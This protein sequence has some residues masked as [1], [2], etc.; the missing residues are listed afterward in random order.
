[1]TIVHFT[2]EVTGGAGGFV[3]NLHLAMRRMGISSLIFTRERSRHPDT[4]VL[5]PSP[6]IA[7]TIR[8]R[9]LTLLGK[10]GL[11]NDKYAMFGIERCPISILNLQQELDGVKPTAFI[12]YWVS[13][14]IDFD[15]I[16]SLRLIYPDTLFIFTCTDEAFLTGGCHF[17]NGCLSYKKSCSDCPAT[18]L[19]GLRKRIS[20][21]F[22]K[23]KNLIKDIDP[24]IIYPT[25]N[26]QKMGN[27]SSV[28][29]GLKSSVIPLGVFTENELEKFNDLKRRNFSQKTNEDSQLT[30]LVRSSSEYR[31]GCDLFVGAIMNIYERNPD[32][33]KNLSVISIG[34]KTLSA[35][36]INKYV[37][38]NNMG[39]VD[40]ETLLSIYAKVDAMVV[41]SREDGGPLMTNE[42]IALGVF[43]I[44]TPIGIS[45]DLIIPGENGMITS[46]SSSEAIAKSI[47]DWMN[48]IHFYKKKY[49]L[50]DINCNVK[51][52]FEGYINS[53]QGLILINE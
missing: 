43:V 15:T 19:A 20:K 38:H 36:N 21:D 50:S 3:L 1:M 14:F 29:K 42:C 12:F 13:Y 32:L 45:G 17:S 52:T 2:T 7:A 11:L 40:R 6:R 4:A 44:S 24:I 16:R 48:A 46:D 39:Y 37:G 22:E 33:L 18:P 25:S 31:K 30:L 53:I 26:I 23:R 8:A 51:L 10:I 49:Y 41:P 47:I 28:L 35:L 34:D 5:K 27:Q 9:F